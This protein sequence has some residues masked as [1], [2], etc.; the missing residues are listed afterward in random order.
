[1]FACSTFQSRLTTCFSILTPFSYIKPT[2]LTLYKKCIFSANHSGQ[3]IDTGIILHLHKNKS[4][5]RKSFAV[6]IQS[7][8]SVGSFLL[9][10]IIELRPCVFCTINASI[11]FAEK[12][13]AMREANSFL[14]PASVLVPGGIS[15]GLQFCFYTYL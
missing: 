2:K 8:T 10:K 13:E 6:L 12:Q 9:V 4:V 7:A 1:M 3:K 15:T 5:L 14:T 11:C